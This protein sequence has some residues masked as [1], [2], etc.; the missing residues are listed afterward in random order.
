MRHAVLAHRDLDF[1][2]WI[3][4]LAKHFL[5]P[6][7]RL[8][9]EA[10]RLRQFDDDD[11][12]GFGQAGCALGNQHVLPV[13]L[14][15]GCN[16]PDAALVQQ[17]ADD[18]LGRPFDDLDHA[19]FGAAFAVVPHDARLDPV[20]VQHRAHFIGWQVDISLPVVADHVA[21]AIPVAVDHAFDFIQQSGADLSNIFDI[22]S[23][24]FLRCPGGGIG[25]RTS[26]RY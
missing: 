26:F 22:E 18:R 19:S 1:H 7:D 15:F 13:A 24:S 21:M 14:V 10:R 6:P 17:A 12:S 16:Q 3:V 5:D 11:L 23:C 9:E 20:L 8:A 2:A 25:R 4:D